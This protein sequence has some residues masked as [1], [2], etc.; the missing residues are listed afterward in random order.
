[1]RTEIGGYLREGRMKYSE[2]VFDGLE[3]APVALTA[4]LAGDNTGKTLVRLEP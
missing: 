2:L 1:M 3:Q 4:M